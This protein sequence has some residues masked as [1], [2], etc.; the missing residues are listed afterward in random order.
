MIRGN[1]KVLVVLTMD[2]VTAWAHGLWILFDLA[3]ESIVEIASYKQ[4]K[5]AA[6]SPLAYSRHH[7][8]C[9][10]SRALELL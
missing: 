9:S 6:H 1:N 10:F 7:M 2:I 5:L 8:V 3:A 4:S